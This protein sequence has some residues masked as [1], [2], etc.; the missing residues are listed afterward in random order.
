[1]QLVGTLKSE[2]EN[3]GYESDRIESILT[4]LESVHLS[5]IRGSRADQPANVVVK[6]MPEHWQQ[7]GDQEVDI[8]IELES[9]RRE[10]SEIGDIESMFDDVF[11]D[12][13]PDS[14]VH[15]KFDAADQSEEDIEIVEM[16]SSS[17]YEKSKPEVDDHFWR[18][19]KEL[20]VGQWLTLCDENDKERRI[21]LAWKSDLLGECTFINWHFKVA[22]D[23]TFNE[24][25]R[26]F[27]RG[28]AQ[29]VENV[30][31]FER[32]FDAVV[33]TLQ[34]RQEKPA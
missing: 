22:A 25:A 17:L 11:N 24:L 4:E 10:L 1:M 5:G 6:A 19:V 32:A 3:I 12:I 15:H 13:N 14:Q 34:W 31:L 8:S 30:P 9:M 18:M 33:S 7:D 26:K 2:L 23:L 27:R 28:E 16:S 29:L 21:K 20:E